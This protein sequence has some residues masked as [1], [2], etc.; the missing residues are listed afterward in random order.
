M[1]FPA[2]IFTAAGLLA[3]ADTPKKFTGIV[4]DNMCKGDHANM[5]QGTTPE[6][7]TRECVEEMGARYA[8]WVGKEVYILS[9]QKSADKFAGRKVTV[10]GNLAGD[11]LTVRGIKAAGR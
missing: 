4:G 11:K 8:L 10:T 2:L 6:K 5:Q 3:A 9:D 1:R 7:C